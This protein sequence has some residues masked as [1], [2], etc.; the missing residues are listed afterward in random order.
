VRFL[1][2]QPSGLQIHVDYKL[3][4]SG[5]ADLAFVDMI[6]P[7]EKSFGRTNLHVEVNG[8]EV[9]P[10]NL[11]AEYQYG[12]PNAL[13]VP[14]DPP[15]ARR[16]TRELSIEYVLRSPENSGAQIA[17]D[18]N[19]F[20]LGARYGFPEPQP[21]NHALSSRPNRPDHTTYTVRVPSDFL[22]LARGVSKGR[23]KGGGEIDYRFELSRDDLPVYVVA[24]RYVAWPVSRRTQS[25][26][27]WTLQPLKEDPTPAASR[28]TTAWNALQKAFGPL[29]KMNSAPHIVE[30]G[31]LHSS[32]TG[33]PGPV[34]I[35]FP[36]GTLVNP[37]ALALGT[38]S[39]QFLIS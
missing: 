38:N 18:Q 17:I 16:E 21:P 10:A 36:R 30:S 14:L 3:Q 26:E 12:Q 6:F 32:G 27:F 4:N 34:A 11:P 15:W 22:V 28:I 7:E 8:H 1:P 37:A 23:K 19:G 33:E 5:T 39:D 24:G 20:Y 29:D 13:R 35:S 2:G 25:A 9:T 31:G